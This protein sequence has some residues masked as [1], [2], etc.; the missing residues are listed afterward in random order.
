MLF[1]IFKALI[2]DILYTITF[3]LLQKWIKDQGQIKEQIKEGIGIPSYLW[4]YK[5]MK[6]HAEIKSFITN[7]LNAPI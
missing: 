5:S 1:T 3:L 4:Q 7:I 6:M 2:E